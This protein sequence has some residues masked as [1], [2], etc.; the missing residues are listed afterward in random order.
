M[1]V[2]VGLKEQ[3]ESQVSE[4]D[5]ECVVSD[6]LETIKTLHFVDS[7]TF[8]NTCSELFA[9]EREGPRMFSV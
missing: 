5:K 1:P 8:E 2:Q 6:V 9:F 3:V 4:T 7:C